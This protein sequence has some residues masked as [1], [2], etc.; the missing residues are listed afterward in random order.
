[1]H[2]AREVQHSGRLVCGGPV[3]GAAPRGSQAR[4]GTEVEV[5]DAASSDRMGRQERDA[6]RGTGVENN[7]VGYM[8]EVLREVCWSVLMRSRCLVLRLTADEWTGCC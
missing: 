8:E 2:K 7:Q 6:R 3:S 1:L 4:L 5:R